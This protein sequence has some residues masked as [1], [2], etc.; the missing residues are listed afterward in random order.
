[1]SKSY[2]EDLSTYLQNVNQHFSVFEQ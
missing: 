1:M 2:F